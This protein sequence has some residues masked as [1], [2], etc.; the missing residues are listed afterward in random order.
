MDTDSVVAALMAKYGWVF[1]GAS[2]F[3]PV[4]RDFVQGFMRGLLDL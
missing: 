1:M 2:L 4:Y 3:W